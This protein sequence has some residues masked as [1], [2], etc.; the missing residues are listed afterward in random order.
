[1]LPRFNICVSVTDTAPKQTVEQI[2]NLS[3]Y[4]PSGP[5]QQIIGSLDYSVAADIG[6]FWRV[7]QLLINPDR[8]IFRKISG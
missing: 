8:N 6:L 2:S 3:L 1:M 5:A 4:L 7:S